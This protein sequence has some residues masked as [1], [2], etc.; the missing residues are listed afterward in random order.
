MKLHVNEGIGIEILNSS[1]DNGQRKKK[2]KKVNKTISCRILCNV[3]NTETKLPQPRPPT[4]RKK[5]KYTSK[6]ITTN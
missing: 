6:I 3:T 1:N 4:N 5:K 2:K